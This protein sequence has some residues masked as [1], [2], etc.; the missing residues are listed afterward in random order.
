MEIE[1][2][3]REISLVDIDSLVLNP[4]NNNSHSQE[5]IERLVKIYRYNGF[6]NPLTIS[7]RSGF[8]LCGHGRIEAAK[9]AGM[10]KLPVMFQD[11]NNEAEEYAH[12]TADN[13]IARW[14]ITD[15]AMVNAELSL[16]EIPDLDVLGIKDFELIEPEVLD[17]IGEDEGPGELPEVPT[18][19][20]G[21]VWILGKHRVMCG[22]SKM[23]DDVEKLMNGEKADM[24]FTDPPY[25]Q[26]TEG[27]CVGSIGAALKKQGKEIESLCDF[28]PKLFLENLPFAFDKNKMNSYVF[29]NKDLL[30]DYLV[31]AR[32]SGYS[33]NVLIWKKPSAIP[34][35]GSHRPDIE[36]LLIFRKSA[37]FNGAIDGVSYS[38]VLEHGREKN[39]VHPTMKPVEMI[40]NQLQISSNKN[41]VVADLF[42]GSGSTLIAC[43]KTNR[44]CYG[45]ELDEKYVDVIINRWQKLTNKQAILESTGQ[46]FEDIKINGFAENVS[47]F[48]G[49]K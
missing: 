27:G 20:R 13:E 11:F 18:T 8:V 35:G 49:E 1:I 29:C 30:P 25:R 44:K 24:V 3:S 19:K 34:I 17:P 10:T 2:K 9:K 42:L 43:E 5:Q 12:L 33:F 15:M 16:L 37:I 23:I 46:T 39:K 47:N 31:W 38:K 4:K 26:E 48:I 40:E 21:D 6:R 14:A 32:D 7:N 28:D 22:D 45:M 36:Y 41:S